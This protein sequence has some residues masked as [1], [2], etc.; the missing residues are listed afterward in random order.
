[1]PVRRPG[2]RL[3]LANLYRPGAP[4]ASVVMSLGLGLTVL[5]AIALIEG[6]LTRQVRAQRELH[7]AKGPEGLRTTFLLVLGAVVFGMVLAGGLNLTVPGHTDAETSLSATQIAGT[8]SPIT[9][10]RYVIISTTIA[11]LIASL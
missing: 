5:V 8:N 4:T 9:S 2:L 6:N 1:M 3:A 11:T 7:R 10:E